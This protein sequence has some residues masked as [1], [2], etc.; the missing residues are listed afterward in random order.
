MV[1]ASP[2]SYPVCGE[3]LEIETEGQPK[4]YARENPM[5]VLITTQL[6]IRF[7]IFVFTFIASSCE[8]K[9]NG[10]NFGKIKM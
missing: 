8:Q 4:R 7:Y 2:G 9:Q 10:D 6:V 3:K 5:T 1:N